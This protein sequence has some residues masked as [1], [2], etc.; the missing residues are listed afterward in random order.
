VPEL[1]E[2][3]VPVGLGTDSPVSNN[4]MD[5]FAE[6]KIA[7]LLHKSSRWDARVLPAQKALDMATIDAAR[8][9]GVGD[10]LGSIEIG[11][12]ADLAV[13]SLRGAHTT[14]FYPANVISHLVY[15]CRGSDVQATLV[16]GNVL[17]DDGLLR[18][19]DQAEVLSRAQET[20]REL[21]GA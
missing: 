12:R 1:Q 16:D 18:T 15:S 20:A 21:F 10:R 5:M 6:M 14:P 9:L 13:V 19:V 17:M 2:Q 11:K 7:T 4:G 3:G 8:A